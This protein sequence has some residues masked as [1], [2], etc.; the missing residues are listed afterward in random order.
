MSSNRQTWTT[1]EPEQAVSAD[2]STLT[3]EPDGSV[4]SS[5]KCPDHDTYTITA[6]E[7]LGE[8]TAIRLELL[9]DDRLPQ[10]GP[11]RA[12]NGNMH[13]SEFQV[14][15][16]DAHGRQVPIA[17]ATAD[18]SEDGLGQLNGPSMASTGPRGASFRKSAALTR[19]SSI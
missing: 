13:L 10:H 18:F 5:G 3:I 8:V 9:A 6:I 16:G 15:V 11:G 4:L 14:F 2:G 17:T 19:L 1:L 12:E 7:P